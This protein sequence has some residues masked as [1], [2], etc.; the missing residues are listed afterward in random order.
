MIKLNRISFS[1]GDEKI[2]QDLDISLDKGRIYCIMGASGIGKT[3][4]LKL[5]SGLE[6]CIKGSVSGTE[7]MKKSYIFQENR[8]LTQMS[9]YENIRFVTDN[10]EKI[11]SALK[12][13]G[14]YEDKDKKIT[15][16]S[17]GME[18][19]VAIAR[20]AAF[21][22]DVFFIDEPLYGLDVK[23]S[24]NILSLIKETVRDKT[25]FIITHSPEEAF[26]LAD[27]IVFLHNKP[28]TSADVVKKE[29]FSDA[30]SIKSYLLA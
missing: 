29:N 7:N 17:G 10:E 22:G 4:L 24:E 2:I 21:D 8:L 27:E 13:T 26:Y 30:E 3:T 23:T 6:K 14:L 20:A 1:Y 12:K 5:I 18:R 15:A 16:L 19:R 25:A 9:V 28:I 11:N